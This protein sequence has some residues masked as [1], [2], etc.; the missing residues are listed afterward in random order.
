MVQLAAAIP[1]RI[2]D[3][4]INDPELLGIGIDIDTG[5]N[6]FDDFF[7]IAAPLATNQFNGKGIAFVKNRIVEKDVAIFGQNLFLTYHLTQF[8]WR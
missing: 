6:A 3:A 7:L 2:I 5:D 1:V 8:A 4:V